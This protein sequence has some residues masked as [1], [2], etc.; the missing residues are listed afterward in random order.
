MRSV[1]EVSYGL[2]AA[3]SYLR[4]HGRPDFDAGCEGHSLVTLHEEAGRVCQVDWLLTLAPKARVVLRASGIHAHL[5][6]ASAGIAVAALPRCLADQHAGLV[7]LSTSI[8]EPRQ[9]VYLG[10]H[11][12]M[13]DVP[14]LRAFIDFTVDAISRAKASLAPQ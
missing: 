7:R 11:A 10:V 1:G 3:E 12:E 8:A 14:R 5:A 2:Y 9:P 6:A 13:R 4:E